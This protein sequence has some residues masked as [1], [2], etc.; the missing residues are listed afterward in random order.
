M[1]Y[2]L[3]TG[4]ISFNILCKWGRARAQILIFLFIQI[5]LSDWSYCTQ[6]VAL[7]PYFNDH[8]MQ[9]DLDWHILLRMRL[10]SH[11]KNNRDSCVIWN[12]LF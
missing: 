12:L 10:K 3:F 6:F 7:K 9:R 5:F 4:Q 2:P 1:L 11:G 8:C